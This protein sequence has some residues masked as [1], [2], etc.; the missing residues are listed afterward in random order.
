VDDMI[1]TKSEAWSHE[2]EWRLYLGDGRNKNAPH[3]D[4][5]FGHRELTGVILGCRMG[6]PE[7]IEVVELVKRLYPH[8]KILQAAT[9][10]HRYELELLETAY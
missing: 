10:N 6:V 2:R 4:V 9:L 3:E 1:Y 7:R 5:K 8:A